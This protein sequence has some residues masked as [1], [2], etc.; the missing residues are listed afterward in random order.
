MA[1]AELARRVAAITADAARHAHDLW[2]TDFRRWEK[3]PGNPVCEVDLAVDAMLRERLSALLPEAGWL[4]E[5]TADSAER[6]ARRRLWVVDPIDGTRDYV[7][8]RPGWA[9]SVALVEDCQPVIAAVGEPGRGRVAERCAAGGRH[10][11]RASRRTHAGRCAAKGRPRPGAG[12]QA[13]LDRAAPGDG[14]GG[15]GGSLGDLSLGQ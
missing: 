9:V 10:P 2:R 11:H 12:V 15:R 1:D 7:R 4:S 13:Q 5:E 8:G 14:G 3:A 6:L